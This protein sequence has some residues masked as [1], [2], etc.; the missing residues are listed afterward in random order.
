MVLFSELTESMFFLMIE[1]FLPRADFM[2]W[3]HTIPETSIYSYPEF[4]NLHWHI[5]YKEL[6]F[7]I[8]VSMIFCRVQVAFSSV[9][10]KYRHLNQNVSNSH[11]RYLA[12][13]TYGSKQLIVIRWLSRF[14]LLRWLAGYRP[15]RYFSAK[16]F[17]PLRHGFITGF[18]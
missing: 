5:C 13:K 10:L 8:S 9:L 14:T 1:S 11:L 15:S 3:F 12:V 4:F 2:F 6:I 7:I 18:L 17:L 16:Y